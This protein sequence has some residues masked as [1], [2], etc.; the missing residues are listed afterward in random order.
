[1]TIDPATL[2][3]AQGGDPLAVAEVLDA[4]AADARKQ[5]RRTAGWVW[6]SSIVVAVICLVGVAMLVTG[7]PTPSQRRSPHELSGGNLSIGVAIG[8]VVGVVIGWTMARAKQR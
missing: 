5:R 6:V 7:T 4:I 2:G 1:M 3:R 8:L